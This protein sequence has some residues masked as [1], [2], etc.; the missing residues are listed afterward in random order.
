MLIK[1]VKEKAKVK[2]HIRRVADIRGFVIG[3]LQAADK[4]FNMVSRK[5]CARNK[6]KVL[7]EVYEEFSLYEYNE[8]TK[9]KELVPK[10]RW[11]KQLFVKG[12]NVV[13]V[14][15]FVDSVKPDKE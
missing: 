2:V 6:V 11:V 1:C 13:I 8:K 5:K 7:K 4:H 14:H 12:D 10:T 3:I 15:R 9:K